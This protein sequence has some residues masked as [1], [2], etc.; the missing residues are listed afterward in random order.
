MD[1]KDL[2]Q[3][4]GGVVLESAYLERV[5]RMAFSALI[6]SKYA[7]VIDSRLMASALIEDCR[8]VAEVHS[9]IGAAERVAL[10]TSLRQC[11]SVNHARNRVIHD[12]WISR[13]GNVM[14][15]LQGERCSHEVTVTAKTVSELDELAD[16]IGCAADHL[17]AAV[18]AALGPASLR[19]QDQLCRDL[20][21]DTAS[22]RGN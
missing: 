2:R 16:R 18:V 19:I 12:D 11:E 17:A 20:R 6:G 14:I 21:H 3:A 10:I 5:L 15:T 7:A 22:D 8:H 9:R 4:I 13:P 1:V